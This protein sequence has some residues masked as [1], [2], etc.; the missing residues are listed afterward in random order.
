MEKRAECSPFQNIYHAPRSNRRLVVVNC[1]ATSEVSA[2]FANIDRFGR[3]QHAPHD[4]HEGPIVAYFRAHRHNRDLH[5]S[6]FGCIIPCMRVI[7]GKHHSRSDVGFVVI[8]A[9][10]FYIVSDEPKM[11]TKQG[12]FVH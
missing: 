3:F 8:F 1:N 11:C 4:I 2:V 5:G 12:G 6:V 10:G 9:E 7:H